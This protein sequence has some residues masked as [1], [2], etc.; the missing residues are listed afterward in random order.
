M[1]LCR[2][3]LTV[4]APFELTNSFIREY[5][6][7]T[8]NTSQATFGDTSQNMLNGTIVYDSTNPTGCSRM[9]LTQNFP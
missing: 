9:N 6:S 1:Q 8:I 5:E 3:S 2:A 7:P 4:L